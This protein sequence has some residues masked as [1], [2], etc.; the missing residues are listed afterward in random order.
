M[1]ERGLAQSLGAHGLP[2]RVIEIAGRGTSPVELWHGLSGARALVVS[3]PIV[4][5]KKKL[6]APLA[7]LALARLRGLHTVVIAHEWADL[8]PLRRALMSVYITAA[9]SVFLSSPAVR[10]DFAGSLAGRL[11]GHAGVIPIPPNIAPPALLS[12]TPFAARL[13]AEKA[14]GRIILGHFGSIYPKKQ[15]GFVLDVAADL[16][17][18]GHDV[19]VA[20]IGGFVKGHDDVE[21]RFRARVREL[22]LDDNV[23]VT[24]YVANA[25]EIFA[26]FGEV[27]AFVYA[28][29]E[30]LTSR[31]GSVLTCLQAGKPLIVNAP[32]SLAEFDHHP[33]FRS[34]MRSGLLRFVPTLCDAGDYA[35][36]VLAALS[37]RPAAADIFAPAWRDAAYALASALR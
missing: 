25:S 17:A 11:A 14:R 28:F 33:V 35:N 19:L 1:F 15:S 37:D 8:N 30:G 7:A 10:Q 31:R 26:L 6:I 5:W 2:T 3:L 9:R 24:G 23:L 29:A 16:K 13:R 34:A 18:K 20:F 22:G 12:D 36:A 4:A 27:D 32:S 21:T